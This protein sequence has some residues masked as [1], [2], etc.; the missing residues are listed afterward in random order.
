MIPGAPPV[1]V[2]SVTVILVTPFCS[3][4]IVL[5]TAATCTNVPAASTPLLYAPSWDQAPPVRLNSISSG[6]PEFQ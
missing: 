4:E 5:P 1:S 3:T 6:L 2:L